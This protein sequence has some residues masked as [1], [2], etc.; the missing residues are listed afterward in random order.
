VTNARLATVAFFA[1]ALVAMLGFALGAPL[2]HDEHQ[3]IASAALLAR[4][5]LL[6]YRDFAYFHTP[7]LVGIYAL[8]FL[9]TD[10]LLLAAR[11][12]STLCAWLIGLG[13]FT[14]ALRRTSSVALALGV[15]ALFLVNPV[16]DYTFPKA[17]NHLLP[18]LLLLLAFA[19][20]CRGA[21]VEKVGWFFVS[22][23]LVAAAAG[24]RISFAPLALPFLVMAWFTPRRHT[25]VAACIGGMFVASIPTLLLFAAAPAQFLFDNLA[26]NSRVNA[27][28]RLA[29]GDERS[30]LVSKAVFLGKVLV[31]PGNLALLAVGAFALFRQRNRWRSDYPTALLFAI[32][33]FVLLGVLAPTPSY[34][35]YYSALA[36]AAAL[37]AAIGLPTRALGPLAAAVAVS[38][39]ASVVQ[40]FETVTRFGKGEWTPMQFHSEGQALR[41]LVGPG[42]VLTLAP[43]VPL[44]GGLPVY[45]PLATGSFAWRTASQIPAT[46]RQRYGFLAAEDLRASLAARP[47]GAILLGYERKQE[48]ALLAYARDHAYRRID[49]PQKISLWL[50]PPDI[51]RP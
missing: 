48:R 12:L 45:P 44:E 46:E 43:I 25:A 17:W 6:P 36:L 26:Y 9:A 24:T 4:E 1:A 42:P 51:S 15:A 31:N 29:S 22:G 2:D 27:L 23:F 37:A 14:I 20:Q 13:L 34:S 32:L 3:F 40:N 47:P 21:R 30:A 7:N 41:K 28:Y 33:P 49:L 50:P 35:Q 8:L 39:V 38:L 11:L 10:H 16:V 19:S 18:A 5:G